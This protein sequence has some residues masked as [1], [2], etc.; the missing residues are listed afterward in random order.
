MSA[1]AFLMTLHNI[2]GVYYT[3]WGPFTTPLLGLTGTVW[4]TPI[5]EHP[6]FN[7]NVERPT[8]PQLTRFCIGDKRISIIEIIGKNYYAFGVNLLQDDN[9]AKMI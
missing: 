4:D 9:G 3:P 5:V 2:K 6:K 8:F 7:S 1:F